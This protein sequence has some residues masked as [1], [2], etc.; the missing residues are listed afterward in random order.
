MVGVGVGSSAAVAEAT[1]AAVSEAPAAITTPAAIRAA[2]IR[3]FLV[4]CLLPPVA[5]SQWSSVRSHGVTGGFRS[6]PRFTCAPVIR[7]PHVTLPS[8]QSNVKV[9]AYAMSGTALF[10]WRADI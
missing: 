8:F 4:I 6:A 9:V 3:V 10:A 5:D 1:P 2:R 7:M